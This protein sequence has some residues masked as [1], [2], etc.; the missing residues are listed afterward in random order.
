MVT[1]TRRENATVYHRAG[2]PAELLAHTDPDGL[3]DH[4]LARYITAA[5]LAASDANPHGYT[6]QQI[7]HW[8]HQLAVHFA[9]TSGAPTCTDIALERLWPMA[10][11][12]HVRAIDALLP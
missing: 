2:D 6:S 12:R 3:D 4:L 8:L 9:A 7:H 1:T 10:G 11:S 5:T